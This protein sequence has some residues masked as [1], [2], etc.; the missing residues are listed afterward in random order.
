MKSNAKILFDE[1]IFPQCF[2]SIVVPMRD[3]AEHLQ[4][5]LESFSLQVDLKNKPLDASAFEILILANN[6]SDDSVALARNWRR[7]NPEINVRVAEINLPKKNSNVGFVRRLLLDE[8]YR[9]LRLN[10][11]G[12]GIIMTTDGDTRVA[13]D[14]IIQNVGEIEA[15]ADAVGGRILLE[16]SEL[17]KMNDKARYFHLL[18]EEYQLLAAEYECFSDA[19]PHDI[20]PR[21]HQ[22]FNGS[23]AVTTD[24]FERAGGIPQVNFLEDVA[25]YHALL[26]VDAKVRHSPQVKVFTSARTAGRSEIGLSF[27]ISR[28][29]TMGKSGENYLVESADAIERRTLARKSLREFWRRENSNESPNADEVFSLARELKIPA[30]LIFSELRKKQFCGA[31]LENIFRAYDESAA[32]SGQN[33]LIPIERAVFDLRKLL[34]NLRQN[35]AATTAV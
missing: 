22:H 4:R 26:R 12:G 18:D 33:N 17:E 16:D 15:G 3:E 14:W 25:F 10:R 23:F 27:Q 9:R 28:W 5:T 20:F 19:L 34:N 30:D 32:R 21:H 11:F 7:Q 6:C 35:V 8:A 13:P 31:L 24:A 29:E 1:P 2:V